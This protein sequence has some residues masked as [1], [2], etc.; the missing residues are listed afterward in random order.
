MLKILIADDENI[1]LNGLKYAIE[2]HP[3]L[4]MSVIAFAK[5]GLDAYDKA[6]SLRP[7]IVITDINMPKCDGLDFISQLKTIKDYDPEI[8]ILTGYNEFEYAKTA[9]NLGVAFFLLKPTKSE[10]LI[11][12][13][14]KSKEK[15]IEKKKIQSQLKDYHSTISHRQ[16]FFLIDLFL[17]KISMPEDIEKKFAEYDIKTKKYFYII[18]IKTRLSDSLLLSYFDLCDNFYL[19]SMSSN[20]HCFLIFDDEPDKIAI[21]EALNRYCDKLTADT[22]TEL[23]IGVSDFYDEYV[24]FSTAYYEALETAEASSDSISFYTHT[25]NG[26]SKEIQFAIDVIARDY[27][28]QIYI[29]DIAHKLHV[30][31]SYLMHQF[32]RETGTTFVSYLTDFR[33]NKALDMLKKGNLKI[34]EVAY[35]VGYSD[36]K[37]FAK[38][39]KKTLG[40]SPSFYI[41]SDKIKKD[42]QQK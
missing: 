2:S 13:L 24:F 17:G 33:M 16:N 11:D 10:E 1:I 36:T 20:E 6:L 37:Y 5:N 7:E 12:A 3:E 41:N 35:N 34:Y 15:Y 21:A 19:C 38:V 23:K 27:Q 18:N 29:N 32:K 8:I 25:S 42:L 39:F 31:P 40:K 26:F 14:N 9:I 30:S 22:S 4:D 28:N